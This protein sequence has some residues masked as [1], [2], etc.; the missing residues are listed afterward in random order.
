MRQR[1]FDR[2]Q[3]ANSPE[4]KSASVSLKATLYRPLPGLALVF[5]EIPVR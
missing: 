2:L 5:S 4:R 1:P 3:H